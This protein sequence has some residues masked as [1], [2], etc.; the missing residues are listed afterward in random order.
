MKSYVN[1]K[2]L[3]QVSMMR[4]YS[5]IYGQCS[6]GIQTKIE[7]MSNP[8]RIANYGNTIGLL[9]D[10]KSVMDNFHT[11]SKPV[12]YIMNCNKTLL[13]YRQGRDQTI[14]DYH[15]Q[16][17]VLIDVIEYNGESVAAE[18]H[19]YEAH[20]RSAGVAVDINVTEEQRTDA[21]S[22]VRDDTTA[23]LFLFGTDK[24][25]FGKLLEDI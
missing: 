5:V 24:I 2:D 20:L 11:S 23:Y 16:F 6:D 18:Q 12:Q 15:K 17:K 3:L 10:I 14:P 25:R 21:L 22:Q 1:N 8:K 19:L 4:I 9:N 7:T 13:A